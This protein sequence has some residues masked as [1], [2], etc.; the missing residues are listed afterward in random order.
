MDVLAR[1][2]SSRVRAAIFRLLFG[3]DEVELH[4]REIA[5]R[6][7]LNEAT[8]RQELRKLR[9][10]DLIQGRRNSNRVYYRAN[11]DHPLYI[12]IHRLVQKT[13]GLVEVFQE[14][15]STADLRFAFVFGSVAK[16]EA[17]ADSDVDLMVIGNLGLRKLTKFLTGVSE[18]IGREVNAHVM[19]ESEYRKRIRGRD[20]FVTHV[21]K[22][23][24]L[25]ITGNRD[26]LEAMG[27]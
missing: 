17:L 4:V 13:S 6:S 2:L 16:G 24:K 26:D 5:R 10:L 27:G 3:I 25:F 20:H 21:L 14:A 18:K 12:E 1:I 15:L 9:Q 8:V 22:G 23:P 7:E 19:S 11:K